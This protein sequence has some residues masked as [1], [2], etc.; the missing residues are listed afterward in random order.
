MKTIYVKT[1]LCLICF[2]LAI[3]SI[4]CSDDDAS[5]NENGISNEETKTIES[6]IFQ[7]VNNHRASISKPSLEA[8]VLAN[9]LAKEHTLYMINKGD[10]SHDNSDL[11]GQRL[12]SEEQASRVGENVAYRYKTAQEV[13]EAWLNSSGHKKNIEGDYTH[14]GISA[15]KSEAGAYY[16][17]QLF[18]K[19]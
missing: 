12:F 2:V 19:K 17:T 14:I 6:E 4:S 15:I 11:R 9:N 10:I 5:V 7:L 13:M 18:L 16:Y 1:R 8:N 3:C